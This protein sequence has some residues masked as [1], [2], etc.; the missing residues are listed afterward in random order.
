MRNYWSKTKIGGKVAFDIL[1]ETLKE[2]AQ[3]LGLATG[4]GR[5]YKQIHVKVILDLSN[6]ISV[7]QMTT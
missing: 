1:K 7:N 6:L 4:N 2:G 5:F 3:T